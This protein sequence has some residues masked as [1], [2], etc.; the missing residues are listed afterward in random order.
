M[1]RLFSGIRAAVSFGRATPRQETPPP[2]PQPAVRD[3][4][5]GALAEIAA[6]QEKMRASIREQQRAEAEDFARDCARAAAVLGSG[7]EAHRLIEF[8]RDRAGVGVS[9]WDATLKRLRAESDASRGSY[10]DHLISL[11]AALRWTVKQSQYGARGADTRFGTSC[12]Q[13]IRDLIGMGF[14]ITA[15]RASTVLRILA[16][17]ESGHILKGR[18][19]F[20][21][22]LKLGAVRDIDKALRKG[23]VIGAADRE[24]AK[25]VLA[26]MHDVGANRATGGPEKADTALVKQLKA[27]AGTGQQDTFFARM[28]THKAAPLFGDPYTARTAQQDDFWID[29]LTETASLLR[30]LRNYS[31]NRDKAA[32]WLLSPASFE[33][34]FGLGD[35][36]KAF[37]FGWWARDTTGEEGFDKNANHLISRLVAEGPAATWPTV[38]TRERLLELQAIGPT[39]T[40]DWPRTYGG[41]AVPHV[42]AFAFE[43]HDP[44]GAL[45][46]LWEKA[47]DAN[48]GPSW[49][50][51]V[52]TALAS[53]GKDRVGEVLRCW[54]ADF[55]SPDLAG[56]DWQTYSD[57]ELLWYPFHYKDYLPVDPPTRESAGYL[58]QVRMAALKVLCGAPGRVIQRPAKP[59]EMRGAGGGMSDNNIIVARGIAFTLSRYSGSFAAPLLE[60]LASRAP[61]RAR[62]ACMQ[63][64]GELGLDGALAL[65]R[66]RRAT[67]DKTT[68]N[69]IDRVLSAMG[70]KFGLSA[71]DMHEIAMADWGVGENGVRSETLGDL[72]VELR[73]TSSRKAELRTIDTKGKV[74]RGISKVFKELEGGEAIAAELEEA[75]SDIAAILPEA[76]RRIEAAWRTG[77]KWDYAG[78]CERLLG[79]G[80]LRTL[81]EKLIWRFT[82]SDGR[83]FVA[84]PQGGRL[85][86]ADGT[87]HAPPAAAA[88]VELWHPMD[89]S[90]DEVT[91]WRNFL[92][93]R[94]LTQP[95]IQAW[96]PIYP[97]TDA[98]LATGTYS[99]RF[100]GHILEQ[101]PAM[102]ILKKRGWIA[103][104]KTMSGNKAE[105]ERVRLLLPH[106]GVAAEYWVAGIGTRI[107]EGK[108]ADVGGELF[109]FITTDRVCFYPLD[110]KSGKPGDRPLPVSEVHPHALGEV[111]Y[112]IDSIVGR[113]SIGS[114]RFWQDRGQDAPHLQ[115]EVAQFAHYRE[116]YASGQTSELGRSRHAFLEAV[117]PSLSIAD[118]CTLTPQFLIVDGKR[119]TYKISLNSGNILIAP[120][121]R[122]LCIVKAGNGGTRESYVPFEGDDIL[123]LI[124]SKAMM[125]AEDDRID[126]P[127]ILRQLSTLR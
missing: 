54:I 24:A 47:G 111:M 100:A 33:A 110:R 75:A 81:A 34:E 117:L 1:N 79:N 3:S 87:E 106:F 55:A 78:W 98:E 62:A 7:P 64:L 5:A 127:T 69:T 48:P 45:F 76:R 61:G 90:A 82:T 115:S 120:N 74:T 56:T 32:A 37:R 25:T 112:D 63:A 96:R 49:F 116:R 95:F 20:S 97:I 108:A 57:I 41:P 122:Y 119:G 51:A 65:G 8:L 126:D 60:S 28:R 4:G 80:L 99:N 50:R 27:I 84:I 118:Q 21:S 30:D 19:G 26:I 10:F 123:S 94:R 53:L 13:L 22:E 40:K 71:E 68:L 46:N 77:R 31:E 124:L 16:D 36:D 42:E 91:S 9:N 39:F 107:Q 12:E 125:L 2:A 11:K 89:A 86:G 93:D 109:A 29:V 103:F 15:E 52:D 113:T 35:G 114:D 102:G 67:R 101:A 83:S 43:G 85:L 23:L 72:T 18:V 121:D 105:H 17:G 66:L 70:G 6:L 92:V 14:E 104:N 44:E 59:R 58:R 88:S 73:V 38:F